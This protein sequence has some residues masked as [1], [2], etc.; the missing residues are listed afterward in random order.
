MSAMPV[1][2]VGMPLSAS[3]GTIGSVPPERTS[4]GRRSK[5]CSN[6]SCASRIAGASGGSSP[7]ARRDQSL[8]LDIG[9][10]GRGLA[11]QPLDLRRDHLRILA[12]REPDRHIRLGLH[13]EHGLLQL[14][15][16]A[17]DRR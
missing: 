7:G 1:M 2:I 3:A 15:R 5:T 11:Q 4:S 17:L 13:R 14:R 16:A 6:A 9:A 12:G 8:D 10:R